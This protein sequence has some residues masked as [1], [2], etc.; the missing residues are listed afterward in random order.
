MTHNIFVHI[1]CL[2]LLVLLIYANTFSAPFQ[3]DERDFIVHNPV[4]KDLG[5][6]LNPSQIRSADY[7]GG[8]IGRYIGYLTFALNYK[9]HGF[10]VT[11]YHLVNIAVH[12]ANSIFVYFLVLLT[13]STPYM[14]K[15]SGVE[16]PTKVGSLTGD[17]IELRARK[18]AL[19]SALIFAAHPLQTEAVTYVFQR[20]ASLVS[21]FYLLSLVAYVKSRLMD[22]GERPAS[23]GETG[24]LRVFTYYGIAFVSAVLAMKTKENA[25]TLPIVI[26]LYEFCFFTPSPNFSA[27]ELRTFRKKRLLRLVPM[28]LTMLIVP[29]TLMIVAGASAG[30]IHMFDH[31]AYG[32]RVLSWQDYLFTQFRVIVTYLALLFFPAGQ[33]IAYDYPVFKSFFDPRVMISFAFLT[34]LFGLGVYLVL[35]AKSKDLRLMGFGILWF[36]ITLSVESSVISIPMVINE[37]RVYLPSAGIII[38]VVAVTLMLAEK[39]SSPRIAR[40]LQAVLVFAVII[41]SV[42]TYFRNSLWGDRI[43]LWEDTAL[44]SP[45]LPGVRDNLGLAYLEKGRQDEAINEFRTAVRLVQTDVTAHMYLALAMR[46]RGDAPESAKEV[47]IAYSI[48]HYFKGVEFMNGGHYQ[49]ATEELDRALKLRPDYPEAY[50]NLGFIY[51]SL[52]LPDKAMECY[53]RAIRLNPEFAEAHNNLGII[54]QSLNIYDKAENEFRLAVTLKPDYAA[55]HFQLG[56]LYYM[57]GRKGVAQMEVAEGLK[58]MPDDAKARELLKAITR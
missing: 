9:I 47:N 43:K 48:I 39:M 46:L 35:R 38:C 49:E 5:Y 54:Y 53:L 20:F 29:V 45:L 23:D 28:L 27:A 44:K 13:F 1:A 16:A 25:F 3:W 30:K 4:V 36:F 2:V 42:A 37:Y 8:L 10:S 56:N 33:N 15:T 41:L 22:N 24:K 19:F 57:M 14:R 58:F 12:I 26:T 34:A 11:G 55:A 32:G 18:A 6:F 50:N 7:Y 51:Q 31:S 40:I 21:F 17:P 52:N